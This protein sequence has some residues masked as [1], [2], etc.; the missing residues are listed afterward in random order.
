MCSWLLSAEFFNTISFKI[1]RLFRFVQ[2]AVVQFQCAIDCLGK[3]FW[4][5]SLSWCL[6]SRR[7]G[8]KH[9]SKWGQSTGKKTFLISSRSRYFWKC[10]TNQY[11][12]YRFTAEIL[13]TK[14]QNW[15]CHNKNHQVSCCAP[16]QVWFQNRR[17]KFRRIERRKIPDDSCATTG[18][19]KSNMLRYQYALL[20]TSRFWKDTTWR[21]PQIVVTYTVRLPVQLQ[22]RKRLA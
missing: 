12:W 6:R 10:Y 17:A 14:E 11:L 5:H 15:Q 2:F 13:L 4:A 16:L 20:N 19:Y 21:Q 9:S 7:I 18:K 22:R 1:D 8:E 3:C